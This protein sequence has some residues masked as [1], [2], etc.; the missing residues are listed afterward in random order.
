MSRANFGAAIREMGRLLGDGTVAGLTERQLLERFVDRRDES[1]FEALVRRHGPMVLGVCRRL[2]HDPHDVDD[3]FQA[4][5]LVLVRKAV[6]IRDGDRL[7]PWLYGVAHRVARRVRAQGA[8]Q[9]ERET[10]GEAMAAHEPVCEIT[11]D[12]FGAELHEELARLPEKYRAPI[13]LCDLG[14][15]THEEAA[16][17]LGWP[18]GTV[19]GRQSRARDL[20]RDRLQRRGLAPTTAAISAALTA[21]AHA[22]L[23]SVLVHSTV[24][25]AMCL[26]AGGA[27]TA[28]A[29]LA[30]ASAVAAAEQVSHGMIWIK[31]KLLAAGL[32]S[33][34]IVAGG[35]GAYTLQDQHGDGVASQET[36][37]AEA[38]PV[39]QTKDKSGDVSQAKLSG[40]PPFA[41]GPEPRERAQ[42]EPITPEI[43]QARQA[44]AEARIN[45]ARSQFESALGQKGQADV[46]QASL[47]ILSA[48]KEA[49]GDRFD[50][51]Q[52]LADHLDRMERLQM[53]YAVPQNPFDVLG[54]QS[55][56]APNEFSTTA[57]YYVAEARL[58][59]AEADAGQE[60]S[61]PP[62]SARIGQSGELIMLG[63]SEST[64]TP[65]GDIDPVHRDPFTRNVLEALDQPIAMSFS[66]DTP[67]E[68]VLRYIQ[69]ATQSDEL[70]SGIP[71]YV[72][73]LSLQSAEVTLR[74]PVN[75][76]LDRIP[77]K[78]TLRLLLRQIR[79]NYIVKDGLVMIGCSDD[80]T[81]LE[82]A[83]F[84][85]G[86]G[87]VP[88]Y[89]L[90]PT[91]GF[92][93]AGGGMGGM[94]GGF[95]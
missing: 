46:Y 78:T 54:I 41:I 39:R 43:A 42:P 50:Q 44:L 94:G 24:R 80:E 1:A 25:A 88:G 75:I 30:S 52:A 65:G 14:G 90:V 10:G 18:I 28:A 47:R 37:E 26:A 89:G 81:F 77:L 5:F 15:C 12:D 40:Q 17:R 57:D 85:G 31:L 63:G 70:P 16:R 93:P 84:H 64:H 22:I 13:V 34:G 7:G 95:R 33:A 56:A 20:L 11:P 23:P 48:E 71:I 62:G 49:L 66:N 69:S 76:D 4:T 60:L 87:G 51:K 3:A 86:Q 38:K 91:G 67:L 32:M 74:S 9:R 73:P 29:G 58:W 6:S 8:R 55:Q 19:K 53:L 36:V 59:K 72:D 35:V 45:I 92:P 2:L 68:D 79:L 27:T 21:D 82:E 83:G 61:S